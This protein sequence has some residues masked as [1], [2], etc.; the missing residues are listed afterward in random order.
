M[1][2]V[3]IFSLIV[4]VGRGPPWSKKGLVMR[5][6]NPDRPPSPL[7]TQAMVNLA[8]A[9]KQA[10]NATTQYKGQSARIPEMNRIV[11]ENLGGR[12]ASGGGYAT[13]HKSPGANGVG[14]LAKQARKHGIAYAG[15]DGGRAAASF[16]GGSF[17]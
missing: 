14:W 2:K 12:G 16:G 9:A 5:S 3:N 17:F 15:S 10:A 8:N 11:S 6:Y 7:Q 13:K 1:V 4:V